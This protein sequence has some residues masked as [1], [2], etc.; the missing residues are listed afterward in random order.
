MESDRPSA[1]GSGIC[2][3]QE[4]SLWK[5]K[6]GDLIFIPRPIYLLMN[7]AYIKRAPYMWQVLWQD[8][9]VL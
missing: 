7:Y 8:A 9:G 3:Q 1:L 4:S 5:Q 2:C 6:R